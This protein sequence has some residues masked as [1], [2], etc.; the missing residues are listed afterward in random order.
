MCI[1][2]TL[3]NTSGISTAVRVTQH[4][5]TDCSVRAVRRHSHNVGATNTTIRRAARIQTPYRYLAQVIW[6][7]LIMHA[8]HNTTLQINCH[9]KLVKRCSRTWRYYSK[10]SSRSDPICESKRRS[11]LAKSWINTSSAELR[12]CA[13]RRHAFKTDSHCRFVTQC[14][15]RKPYGAWVIDLCPVVQAPDYLVN[16]GHLVTGS[17]RWPNSWHLVFHVKTL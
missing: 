10:P 4:G 14:L 8:F 13:S 17:V 3:A 16:D 5:W 11:A 9:W 6:P 15:P 1:A 2:V 12:N 7:S